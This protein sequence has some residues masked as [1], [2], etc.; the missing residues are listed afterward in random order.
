MR[1]GAISDLHIDLHPCGSRIAEFL[2]DLAEE[3]GLDALLIAGDVAG[4]CGTTD[5]FMAELEK[6]LEEKGGIPVWFCL[7]NHDVWNRE[8]PGLTMDEAIRRMRSRKGFLQNDIVPLTGRTCLVAGIGWWDFSLADRTRFT[9]EDLLRYSFGGREWRSHGWTDTG[10]IDD[11]ELTKR[12]NDE[13]L[14]LVRSVPDKDVVLMT[15]MINHPAYK[16]PADHPNYAIFCYFNGYLG[17]EGLFEIARE[18]NVKA[19]ISGHVHFRGRTEENGTVY[20]CPNLGGPA[21]F[22]Y[23]VPEELLAPEW[24]EKRAALPAD[25]KPWEVNALLRPMDETPETLRFHVENALDIIEIE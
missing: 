11:R 18:P 16:V 21:E 7:G 12:W 9:D 10:G 4:Y 2:A 19:A 22:L 25:A 23:R 24:R 5:R 13:L 17:S 1:L 15:H 8:E 14:A 6:R 3:R 20:T